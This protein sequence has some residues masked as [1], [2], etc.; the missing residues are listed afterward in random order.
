MSNCWMLD[1]VD[2]DSE[3]VATSMAASFDFLERLAFE[4]MKVAT[5]VVSTK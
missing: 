4:T 1:G 3:S 5:C 2:L